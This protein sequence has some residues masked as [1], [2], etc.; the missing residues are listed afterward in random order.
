MIKRLGIQQGEYF[1]VSMHREENIDSEKN[2][3]DLFESLNK[4]AKIY[5]KKIIVSTHPRTRKKL[6]TLNANNF[7]PLIEFMKPLGFFDYI[8]LQ[9]DA[10]CA[11][12]DSGTITE[13]SS[14]LGFPAITVR[15]AHE[16]PEG[17][18]EGTLI[19]A[20]LKSDDI[21]NAINIV[22]Q[23]RKRIQMAYISLMIMMSIMFHKKL[24]E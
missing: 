6:E 14:V 9:K 13:E 2:F 10:F 21:L 5:K 18:D 19:M 4:I 7:N 16:R 12:S 11:I 20:G 3:P 8:A 24:L 15:Q 1:I 22:T 23:Q 17:M